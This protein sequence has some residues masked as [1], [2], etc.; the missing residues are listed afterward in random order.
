MKKVLSALAALSLMATTLIGST[1][2]SAAGGSTLKKVTTVRKTSLI[3]ELNTM[4]KDL[5]KGESH[6]LFEVP[7]GGERGDYRPYGE[8]TAELFQLYGGTFAGKNTVSV[9]PSR[10]EVFAP[11][12]FKVDSTEV[13][14]FSTD[15]N[16]WMKWFTDDNP[17]AGAI[18]LKGAAGILW[19]VKTPAS[20]VR[21]QFPFW[22]PQEYWGIVPTANK[23][24]PVL[25]DGDSEWTT[26]KGT[27]EYF[28]FGEKGFSG[29]VFLSK[30]N[31]D[32]KIPWD[33]VCLKDALIVPGEYGGERGP[34]YFSA[35]MAVLNDPT[36]AEYYPTRVQLE[37]EDSTRFFYDGNI[38]DKPDPKETVEGVSYVTEIPFMKGYTVGE[39]IPEGESDGMYVVFPAPKYPRSTFDIQTVKN[40]N[41]LGSA[42]NALYIN[43]QK[44]IINNVY[45][46]GPKLELTIFSFDMFTVREQGGLM[47]YVKMPKGQ[48]GLDTTDLKLSLCI[49]GESGNTKSWPEVGKGEAFLL[50]KGTKE[51][52]PTKCGNS[53][54][55]TPSG[56]EGWVRIPWTL[57]TG[58]GG[59]VPGDVVCNLVIYITSFGGNMGGFTIGSL[60]QATNDVMSKDGVVMNGSGKIQN[61]FTGEE[62]TKADLEG[63]GKEPGGETK[64]DENKD[65]DDKPEPDNSQKPDTDTPRPDDGKNPPTGEHAAAAAVIAAACAAAVAAM[66][67][68]KKGRCCR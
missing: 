30:D 58:N 40:P 50:K 23:D 45:G 19:Y 66:L 49:N 1:A 53:S 36:K 18:S 51:W 32:A 67:L 52:M 65:P 26:V 41:P 42:Y 12:M 31:W 5:K 4:A 10:S 3:T 8:G 55:P 9:T 63:S 14:P 64:P 38:I 56:F 47:F 37:G 39:Q 59:I 6:T 57:I 2:V 21:A 46:K 29:Y 44:E 16:I 60:M 43:N 15:R 11:L 25:R 13:E 22:S 24:I 20:K 27:G 62:M 35:P 34:M 48:N 28:N 54:V 68:R 7:A 61:L 17:E 33:D